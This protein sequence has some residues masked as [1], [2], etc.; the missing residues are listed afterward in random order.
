[1][2]D[3]ARFLAGLNA[4]RW[5][6]VFRPLAS[7]RTAPFLAEA[8]L[9]PEMA[10]SPASLQR[11][12]RA[13]L[14]AFMSDMSGKQD[15][16]ES[17]DV[18]RQL[19]RTV[20]AL[21]SSYSSDSVERLLTWAI[22]HE[23]DP[24]ENSRWSGW[25]CLFVHLAAH[26]EVNGGPGDSLPANVVDVVVPRFGR[27]AFADLNRRIDEA[28]RSPLHAEVAESVAYD[29]A[30]FTEGGPTPADDLDLVAVMVTDERAYQTCQEFGRTLPDR[31]F[32]RLM[33]WAGEEASRCGRMSDDM[34][35]AP[36]PLWRPPGAPLLT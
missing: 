34:V 6:M 7:N 22:R 29:S 27:D 16:L 8:G 19:A 1:M 12:A 9:P 36:D 28:R 4:A 31:D 17:P 14:S 5:R 30:T 15:R 35:F 10:S 18:D 2:D 11:A 26:R 21:E 25:S 32:T 13:H 3:R 33:A 24:A 23:V 20:D